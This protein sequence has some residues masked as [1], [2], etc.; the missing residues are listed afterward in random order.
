VGELPV[1]DGAQ[2]AGFV[3]VVPGAG[4][5]VHEGDPLGL[6]SVIAQPLR[7]LLDERRRLADESAPVDVVPALDLK[8]RRTAPSSRPFEKID[9][10]RIRIQLVEPDQRFEIG[11]EALGLEDARAF[12]EVHH[13][14]GLPQDLVGWL[15]REHLGDGIA[16]RV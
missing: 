6:R 8:Q 10:E 7:S 9:A 5:A 12:D 16:A 1:D 15:V 13:E 11:V 14:E 4:V 2:R 3:Q